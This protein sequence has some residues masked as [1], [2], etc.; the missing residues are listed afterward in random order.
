MQPTV[1]G[2]AVEP[3]TTRV[4]RR[5]THDN[6]AWIV[7]GDDE[8]K[9]RFKEL[10]ASAKRSVHLSTFSVDWD[11]VL[12]DLGLASVLDRGVDVRVV[13]DSSALEHESGERLA[14]ELGRRGNLS[15]Y[16][17]PRFGPTVRDELLIA[18]PTV[19]AALGPGSGDSGVLTHRQGFLLVDRSYVMIGGGLVSCA[20]PEARA[21]GDPPRVHSVHAVFRA[22]REARRLAAG[23][24]HY[25]GLVRTGS[26]RGRLWVDTA[27]LAEEPRAR[28]VQAK[29]RWWCSP[30]ARH[31]LLPLARGPV[32]Q[33]DKTD[34]HVWICERIMRARRYVY[35][36]VPQLVSTSRSG[37]ILIR[38]LASRLV[39]SY[40]E[41]SSG[42]RLR[43]A[44]DDEQGQ[45]EDWPEES[46]EDDGQGDSNDEDT[47]DGPSATD[48]GA[49]AAPFRCVLMI[50][51]SDDRLSEAGLHAS[52]AFFGQCVREAGVEPDQLC[53]R[54]FVGRPMSVTEQT[55]ID[56]KA[57]APPRG[58]WAAR[59]AQGPTAGTQAAA[60][61]SSSSSP[62][63][64]SRAC[65]L[66]VGD[67][68]GAAPPDGT[69]AG[70]PSA[71]PPPLFGSCDL[72]VASSIV[73]CDGRAC[74]ISGTPWA[75]RGM[76]RD[77]ADSS[78]AMSCVDAERVAELQNCLWSSRG[79][80]PRGVRGE[81]LAFDDLFA[82][83]RCRDLA[84]AKR[85]R[86]F[87]KIRLW[88]SGDPQMYAVA[89]SV[90][91]LLL[92]STAIST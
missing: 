61:A 13:L 1:I 70:A 72:A 87:R 55:A 40:E 15:V 86:L 33:P 84:A 81:S 53:N 68:P 78:C 9:K 19:M 64:P 36:E 45:G 20:R 67:D 69:A 73:V 8:W 49:A 89:T 4:R 75:D 56:W 23:Q 18:T 26:D 77:R 38:T 17:A 63:P 22:G 28:G 88:E 48:L 16:V 90:L 66:L 71:P 85:Q 5:R 30:A 12:D 2:N 82:L 11:H 62:D 41:E 92:G 32:D 3:V 60:A 14:A 25:C 35:V 29:L 59:P 34:E 42:R 51:R 74:L 91:K 7:G 39:R 57:A 65:P 37:N 52:L 43:D 6:V 47:G 44:A 83:C 76:V 31:V 24:A 54:L 46:R 10:I 21:A 58:F 80:R 50:G 27:S 79:A